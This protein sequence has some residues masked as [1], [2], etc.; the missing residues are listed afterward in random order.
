MSAHARDSHPVRAGLKGIEMSPVVKY[1]YLK[2]QWIAANPSATPD[3][4]QAAMIALA[5]KAGL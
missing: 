5:R 2:R 4:Y 3:E 1:E